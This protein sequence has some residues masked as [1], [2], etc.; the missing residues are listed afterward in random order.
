MPRRPTDS[1]HP[2]VRCLYSQ[3]PSFA[4]HFS[5]GSSGSTYRRAPPRSRPNTAQHPAAVRPQQLCKLLPGFPATR[6]REKAPRPGSPRPAGELGARDLLS[7]GPR[8][9]GFSAGLP[10]GARDWG[11]AARPGIRAGWAAPPRPAGWPPPGRADRAAPAGRPARRACAAPTRVAA[12]RGHTRPPL[13]RPAAGP[14]GAGAPAGPGRACPRRGRLAPATEAR[15]GD[16]AG[17]PLTAAAPLGSG[18]GASRGLRRGGDGGVTG[19]RG[20]PSCGSCGLPGLPSLQRRRRRRLGLYGQDSG[21]APTSA[22]AAA[23]NGST[24]HETLDVRAVGA[25]PHLS[26]A[27]RSAGP[28]PGPSHVVQTC[29]PPVAAAILEAPP[30]AGRRHAG[31]TRRSP[32]P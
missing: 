9:R 19:A 27:S 8:R 25:E 21:S 17:P 28:G 11:H 12:G 20:G 31:P 13:G 30:G 29:L 6:V 22:T 26:R 3:S 1:K 2:S 24:C 15:E 32:S 14:E 18:P 5:P 4:N 23:P 16:G 10:L 7:A